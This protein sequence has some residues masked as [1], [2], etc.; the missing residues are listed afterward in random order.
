MAHLWLSISSCIETLPQ[1][2]VQRYLFPTSKTGSQK[3][4]RPACRPLMAAPWVRFVVK[5]LEEDLKRFHTPSSDKTKHIFAEYLEV[6]VTAS[7]KWLNFEPQLARRTLDDLVV[8][9]GDAV[10]RSRPLSENGTPAHLVKREEL[11]KA[12]RFL[13]G[14]VAAN[15]KALAQ[16]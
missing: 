5:K 4:C 16:H 7:W 10:H 8:K 3:P 2:S 14:L 6:D 12:I 11:E 15:E 9:R 13:K 1:G